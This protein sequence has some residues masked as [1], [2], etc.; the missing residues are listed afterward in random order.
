[1]NITFDTWVTRTLG[2]RYPILVGGMMWLGRSELVAAAVRAGATGFISALTFPEPGKLRDEIAR[3]RDLAGSDRFGV[4][5]Y[6]SNHKEGGEEL[7]PLI[8]VILEMDV[9][10]VETSGGPPNLLVEHLKQSDIKIIHK[11]PTI[12]YA[13]SAIKAGVDA[14]ILV[15]GECGGHPGST[16]MGSFVQGAFGPES[17]DVPV[18]LAGGVGRG[19]QLM[20]ALAMGCEGV[21]MGTRMMV[22]TEAIPH[23]EIK[24]RIVKSDGSDSVIVQSIFNH[25]HRVMSNEA[26]NEVL[27][28]ERQGIDQFESYRPLV[29]GDVTWNA[30]QTGDHRYGM[31]D[32]GQAACFAN[33]VESA[34][35][36]IAAMIEEA[37]ASQKALLE[38][39]K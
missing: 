12:R 6:I 17:L 8:D 15:G 16:M 35:K 10:F 22:A 7:L 38:K 34:E 5:L 14:I 26:T 25:H 30:L 39:C 29:A 13:Q 19:S 24:N 21:L 37:T 33:I 9:P 28:M 4:N 23:I 36:V 18:I 3:C 2:I 31:I 32:M 27:E 1:M 20:A 11:V